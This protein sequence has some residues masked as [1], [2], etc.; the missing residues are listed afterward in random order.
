MSFF[1]L[2]NKE[3]KIRDYWGNVQAG[4]YEAYTNAVSPKKD[5]AVRGYSHNVKLDPS[6]GY[7]TLGTHMQ[8]I[9]IQ[10]VCEMGNFRQFKDNVSYLTFT[11]KEVAEGDKHWAAYGKEFII[12]PLEILDAFYKMKREQ[13]MYGKTPITPNKTIRFQL[14]H[15]IRQKD[16][17]RRSFSSRQQLDQWLKPQPKHMI[18]LSLRNGLAFNINFN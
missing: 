18:I 9:I 13:K 7:D 4:I 10:I 15:I 6:C 14:K 1:F 2:D 16:Y 12:R 5:K 8:H 11:V 17:W 3:Q